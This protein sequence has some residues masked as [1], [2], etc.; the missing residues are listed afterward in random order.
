M[1]EH[2]SDVSAR[3]L[4]AGMNVL[5]GQSQSGSSSLLRVPIRFQGQH[6]LV[7]RKVQGSTFISLIVNTVENAIFN[8]SKRD[9]RSI[10][11]LSDPRID[12]TDLCVSLCRPLALPLSI[13]LRC[14]VGLAL[15]WWI[16]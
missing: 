7:T 2:N 4:R 14:T 16:S 8:T 15:L 1:R 12:M 9:F 10:I 6:F 5:L 11:E 3:L 13:L